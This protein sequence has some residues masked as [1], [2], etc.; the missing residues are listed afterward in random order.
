MMRS[1][2]S[3]SHAIKIN[4]KPRGHIVQPEGL[5]QGDPLSTY[6]FLICAEGLSSLLRKLVKDGLMKGVVACLRD[7]EI[8]HLFFADYNLIF[9]R[10]I[11]ED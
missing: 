9:C 8:S 11:R 2:R 7:P 3:V 10:A 5:R 6:L 1:V 4:G